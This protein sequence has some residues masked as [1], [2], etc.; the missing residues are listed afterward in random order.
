MEGLLLQTGKYLSGW[1]KMG[2]IKFSKKFQKRLMETSVTVGFQKLIDERLHRS[3]LVRYNYRA[4]GY[5][6]IKKVFV[7]TPAEDAELIA[8]YRSFIKEDDGWD[9]IAIKLAKAV[10]SRLTYVRDENNWGYTEFWAR[11]IDVHRKKTDDCDGYSVLTVYL[12]GL[13]GIPA[14]RRY[15][16]AGNVVGGGHATALYLSLADNEIYPLEG[17]YY[18]SETNKNFLKVPLYKNKRY[19]DT[20]WITNEKKS[21]SGSRFFK[22]VNGL[23]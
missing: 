23:K 12:W 13:F 21:Y 10:N 7:Q 19:L 20:W 6:N 11:P 22:F 1:H 4:R 16:R 9:E 5:E 18:P 2:K 8:H 14:Y 3:I 15:V 17:S